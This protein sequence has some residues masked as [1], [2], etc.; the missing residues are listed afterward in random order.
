[1]VQR[2]NQH[3]PSKH[4]ALSGRRWSWLHFALIAWHLPNYVHSLCSRE[5]HETPNSN[6]AWW[7]IG[8]E[9][10]WISPKSNFPSRFSTTGAFELFPQRWEAV[11]KDERVDQLRRPGSLRPGQSIKQIFINFTSFRPRSDPRKRGQPKHLLPRNPSQKTKHNA[12]SRSGGE[13]SIFRKP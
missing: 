6:Q 5:L 12:A 1:M 10:N 3:Q 13:P 4:R 11:P 8:I 7:Q 9:H 2:N